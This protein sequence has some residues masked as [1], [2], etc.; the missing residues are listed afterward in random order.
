MRKL[1]YTNHPERKAQE[2]GRLD[3]VTL[4][5]IKAYALVML[6]ACLVTILTILVR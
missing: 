5:V 2:R 6:G 1:L 3:L 4:T